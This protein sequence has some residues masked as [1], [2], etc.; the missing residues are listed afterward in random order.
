[1][2]EEE[3][4]QMAPGLMQALAPEEVEESPN[5]RPRRRKTDDPMS[6]LR[7][8]VPK[9]RLGQM[10]MAGKVL[11]YAQALATCPPITEVAI[12]D[13]CVPTL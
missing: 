11:T 8:W 9:T 7:T 10:V 3:I 13:A 12:I 1:M 4:V 6:G 5:G 2:T